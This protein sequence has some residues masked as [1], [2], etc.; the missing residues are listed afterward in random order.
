ML[1]QLRRSRSRRQLQFRTS[2]FIRRLTQIVQPQLQLVTPFA[3]FASFGSSF[4]HF[5]FLFFSSFWGVP[6]D[7]LYCCK[8]TKTV[9]RLQLQQRRVLAVLIAFWGPTRACLIMAPYHLPSSQS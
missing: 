6:F 4:L 2:S 5:Y 8:E 3:P 9:V 1:L 7:S